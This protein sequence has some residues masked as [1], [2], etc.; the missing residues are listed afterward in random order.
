MRAAG[1]IGTC[2]VGTEYAGAVALA[3]LLKA[4]PKIDRTLVLVLGCIY[5]WVTR[6]IISCCT[7]QENTPNR[8]P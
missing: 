6:Q 2:F 1:C 3:I 7:E 4:M 8:E 5:Y